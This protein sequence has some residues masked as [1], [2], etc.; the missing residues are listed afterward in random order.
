MYDAGINF[1]STSPEAAPLPQLTVDTAPHTEPPPDLHIGNDG[2]MRVWPFPQQFAPVEG[3]ERSLAEHCE[4]LLVGETALSGTLL[5]FEPARKAL[6]LLLTRTGAVEDVDMCRVQML[7]LTRPVGMLCPQQRLNPRTPRSQAQPYQLTLSDGVQLKG[8]TVGHVEHPL[9][10]FIF[11]PVDEYAVER[12]FH[13]SAA[14]R[15]RQ[16]GERLGD[17]LVETQVISRDSLDTALKTQEE[18][19][20]QKLGDILTRTQSISRED[21]AAALKRQ[22]TMPVVR[23]GEALVQMKCISEEQLKSALE[24]QRQDRK[25]PLGQILLKSGLINEHRLRQALT[26]KLGIPFVELDSF[27][28]ELDATARLTEEVARKHDAMPLYVEHKT[29]VVAFADPL[30]GGLVQSLSF[31]TQMRVS[32]VMA[33]PEAI[34]RAIARVYGA[35]NSA[36]SAGAGTDI[37]A[38]PNDAINYSGGTHE[39]ASTEDLLSQMEFASAEDSDAGETQVTESDNSLVK[40]VNKILLD[41]HR[42][43][44]TDIHIENYSG[45]QNSCVRFRKDGALYDYLTIPH[46][47][48]NAI[49][50]RLKIMSALDIS[51]KRRPQDGKL[52]FALPKMPKLEFR[53][54]TIPTVNGLEDVVMRLLSGATLRS[55]D[56]IGLDNT[57]AGRL[58][59]LVA[60]PHGMILVCGP[61]GSGKTTTLH[62]LLAEI[63][64]RECKIWTAE[65][66]V[67]I[68]HPGLRQVQVNTK[69]GWT[70]AATLRAF[71]RGDPDVIMV[72]E[73]RDLDT[74]HIAMEASLTGHL[75]LSTLHTNSAVDSVVRLLDMGL[76][77]FNFADALLGVLAQRLARRVCGACGVKEPA[78]EDEIQ[79]LAVEYCADT[80]EHPAGVA[81][82]WQAAANGPILLARARGCPECAN[83]GYS[84]RVG[85]YELFVNDRKARALMQKKGAMEELLAAAKA[86][87]MTTLRQSGIENIIAGVTDLKQVRAVCG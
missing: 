23:L 41:A 33:H 50:S 44:A 60:K 40:L 71:L 11:H 47:F 7:K 20:G 15:E 76:D 37:P 53:I 63:N 59:Q 27:T 52:E 43:R 81:A 34:E 75:V 58:R 2:D 87:G 45:R 16:I 21:I 74:A 48:R 79:S 72:G 69:I 18:A 4:L 68:T 31:H 66:P 57:I 54:A 64:R 3:A 78:G 39:H 55:L 85:L 26:E 38:N 65:D 13:P 19:R 62:S 42:A 14:I 17:F 83:S 82:R 32:P 12:R 70:F 6:S 1:T 24:Q 8:D 56:K 49:I 80:N 5:S 35:T 10:L 77:P 28:P 61:T 73:M 25:T 29:M 84:G 46:R 86:A 67:E 30:N 9:G 22:E 51:E 36:W